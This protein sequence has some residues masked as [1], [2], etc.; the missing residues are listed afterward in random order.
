MIIEWSFTNWRFSQ[1]IKS[2]CSKVCFVWIRCRE[3]FQVRSDDFDIRSL[4]RGILKKSMAFILMRIELF[5]FQFSAQTKQWIKVVF[6]CF[7]TIIFQIRKSYKDMDRLK[8]M[9]ISLKHGYGKVC[10]KNNYPKSS[11]NLPHICTAFYNRF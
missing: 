11:R 5:F 10:C 3:Q 2:L 6:V 7:I 1:R 8:N 4:R 9:N